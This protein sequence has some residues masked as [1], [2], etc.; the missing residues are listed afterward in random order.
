MHWL[1]WNSL[2]FGYQLQLWTSKLAHWFLVP[3]SERVCWTKL[4]LSSVSF[5]TLQIVLPGIL[6]A[7]CLSSVCCNDLA[8]WLPFNI[9][10]HRRMLLA[11]YLAE[12]TIVWKVFNFF[13]ADTYRFCLVQR[14]SVV[15]WWACCVPFCWSCSLSTGCARRMREATPWMSPSGRPRS[16]RTCAAATRSSTL[17]PQPKTRS[18]R[19][20]P[21]HCHP[22]VC[23]RDKCMETNC[24][25]T[26]GLSCNS[27][28]CASVRGQC[29]A[30]FVLL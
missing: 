17:N 3:S 15:Q 24:S 4:W 27:A 5:F 29:K 10:R 30:A 13:P 2:V 8:Q 28:S 18:S 7:K 26:I 16:T 21:P 23:S 14:W 25:S 19:L 6:L 22:H 1:S 20:N 9:C 11:I 12:M